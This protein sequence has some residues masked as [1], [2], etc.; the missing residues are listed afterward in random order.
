MS[1]PL[2]PKPR[3]NTAASHEK[4]GEGGGVA[5]TPVPADDLLETSIQA[6]ID[7]FYVE[8]GLG[9]E[10]TFLTSLPLC[11]TPE[12]SIWDREDYLQSLFKSNDQNRNFLGIQKKKK[13]KRRK[14]VKEN[15]ERWKIALEQVK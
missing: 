11:S 14:I 8:N 2:P 6:R 12:V 7:G 13:L 15:R 9:G 4:V 1:S 10:T 5:G 3:D